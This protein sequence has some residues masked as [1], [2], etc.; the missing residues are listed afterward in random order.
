[1]AYPEHA[2]P[3][4][5]PTF[6]SA[7]RSLQELL[8]PLTRTY[9]SGEPH[10]R[11]CHHM[12]DNSL[13]PCHS[14]GLNSRGCLRV[15]S[16]SGLSGQTNLARGWVAAPSPLVHTTFNALAVLLSVVWDVAVQQI[17]KSSGGSG[18]GHPAWVFCSLAL[19]SVPRTAE[20]G[21]KEERPVLPSPGWGAEPADVRASCPSTGVAPGTCSGEGGG[22]VHRES[23]R[24]LTLPWETGNKPPATTGASGFPAASLCSS[25]LYPLRYL[26]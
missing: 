11:C 17:S 15:I 20:G 19:A 10:A 2:Q 21:K 13:S 9:C 12:R 26:G 18:V 5:A 22:C 3:A 25:C 16:G 23:S 4:P 1:M 8:Q 14:P 7:D 6:C 24:V